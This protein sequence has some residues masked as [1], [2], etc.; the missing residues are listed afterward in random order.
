MRGRERSLPPAFVSTLTV[1]NGPLFAD[2]VRD[3]SRNGRVE[4]D[5]VEHSA[6]VRICHGEAV[7]GHAHNDRPGVD[8]ELAAILPESL[9]RM[10]WARPR[11]AV[12]VG[13]E[14][15]DLNVVL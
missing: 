12:G 2:E 9:G 8:V 11:F 7:G 3:D 13:D 15:R 4:A 6:V 10:D 5:D 14:G 1:S